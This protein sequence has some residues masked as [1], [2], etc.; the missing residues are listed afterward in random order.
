MVDKTQKIN[1][2]NRSDVYCASGVL[3]YGWNAFTTTPYYLSQ[4]FSGSLRGV[5]RGHYILF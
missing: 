2:Y 4:L 5:I 1:D 3:P